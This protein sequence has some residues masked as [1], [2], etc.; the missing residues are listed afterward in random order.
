MFAHW[1]VR[2]KVKFY[3]AKYSKL[4]KFWEKDDKSLIFSSNLTQAN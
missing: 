4:G 2:K 3:K 1:F